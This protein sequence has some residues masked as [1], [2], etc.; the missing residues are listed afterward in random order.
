MESGVGI[1]ADREVRK[2]LPEVVPLSRDLNE[3]NSKPH[4]GLGIGCSELW[5]SKCKR[6]EAGM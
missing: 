5:N 3:G 2:S 6:P 1:M 4:P